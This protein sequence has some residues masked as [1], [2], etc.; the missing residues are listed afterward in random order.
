MITEIKEAY[1]KDKRAQQGLKGKTKPDSGFT[2]C[3]QG[4]IRFYRL[5]YVPQSVRQDLVEDMHSLPAHGR[6]G[7]T[8][9]MKRIKGHFF[10]PGLRK[11]IEAVV[12]ECNVCLKTK[13]STHAPYSKLQSLKTPAMPW[14]SIAFDFI[15]KLPPSKE[16]M[17]GTTCDSIWVVTDQ[18]SK[19]AHFVPYKESSTCLCSVVV[20]ILPSRFCL[21]AWLFLPS[22]TLDCEC[23]CMT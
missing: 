11:T 5:V 22:S 6:Q 21:H 23:R 3:D 13:A 15:V 20:S 17:V 1:A 18:H 16:P 10:M 8:K 19:Q 7:V 2:T 9:T 14:I 12:G 4:L